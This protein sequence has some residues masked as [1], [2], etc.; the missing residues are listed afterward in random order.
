MSAPIPTCNA[1][2]G[3]S[4]R[5]WVEGTC[6]GNCPAQMQ[7]LAL[8]KEIDELLAAARNPLQMI[9]PHD[10]PTDKIKAVLD[11]ITVYV[12]ECCQAM[13]EEECRHWKE[14]R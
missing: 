9:W 2:G 11:G 8:L 7:A 3:T 10:L 4:W 13:A 6:C 14:R 12:D 5:H 1:C